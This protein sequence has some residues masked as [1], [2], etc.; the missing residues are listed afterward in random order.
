MDEVESARIQG[1]TLLI[2]E[3]NTQQ[4]HGP[5]AISE[6]ART[7]VL[8]NEQVILLQNCHQISP[9]IQLCSP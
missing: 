3:N 8:S 9:E 5:G 1:A 7:E 4:V 2:S 6:D